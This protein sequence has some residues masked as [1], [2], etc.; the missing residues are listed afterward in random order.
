MQ[1]RAALN[2]V[3]VCVYNME[4]SEDIEKVLISLYEALKDAGVDFDECSV[5]I[6]DEEKGVI[7]SYFI[8]S[9]RVNVETGMKP[10]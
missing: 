8:T 2:R 5:Q 6:M 3:R 4:K 9:A 1:G 7:E 10:M